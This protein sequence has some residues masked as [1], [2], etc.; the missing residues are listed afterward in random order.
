M[1]CV[2]RAAGTSRTQPQHARQTSASTPPDTH[3]CATCSASTRPSPPPTPLPPPLPACAQPLARPRSSG[4]TDC[5]R[6][7][8]D[9]RLTSVEAADDN[10]AR[11]MISG[12]L[13]AFAGSTL[14]ARIVA[15]TPAAPAPYQSLGLPIVSITGAHS[16]F[17]VWTQTVAAMMV[18]ISS[19]L[20]PARLSWNASVTLT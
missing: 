4:G 1:A 18:V 11:V 9:D 15:P 12:T 19:V 16:T 14:I 10:S 17:Q 8:S 5:A 3:G 20:N 7:I 2:R 6:K 13:C